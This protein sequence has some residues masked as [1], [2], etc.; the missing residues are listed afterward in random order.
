MCVSEGMIKWIQ[1][2]LHT[3]MIEFHL[4]AWMIWLSTCQPNEVRINNMGRGQWI[5]KINYSKIQVHYNHI[6]TD[7]KWSFHMYQF[8]IFNERT[9][10]H[11]TDA[12]STLLPRVSY[13]S[14]TDCIVG[15]LSPHDFNHRFKN[16]NT[17]TNSS[18][19][20]YFD[21][22]VWPDTLSDLI[23][24][25]AQT[26]ESELWIW[27]SWIK[28][29]SRWR[30]QSKYHFDPIASWLFRLIQNGWVGSI[31]HWVKKI[32]LAWWSPTRYFIRL[33]EFVWVFNSFLT[34]VLIESNKIKHLFKIKKSHIKT[35]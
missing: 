13:N 32:G 5:K 27:H 1:G 10:S 34:T 8:S 21:H 23:E 24:F 33:L 12:W 6:A 17:I 25:L 18:R 29:T 11:Y 16:W 30:S 35:T 26:I 7:C 14:K 4:D 22:Q 15:P 9:W 28:P 2:A 31:R 3:I 20:L 19:V